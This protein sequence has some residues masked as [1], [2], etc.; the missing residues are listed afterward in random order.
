MAF[1]VYKNALKL[2]G[3]KKQKEIKKAAGFIVK[4][5]GPEPGMGGEG[6]KKRV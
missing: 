5:E 1:C 4:L 6:I 3:A 2:E